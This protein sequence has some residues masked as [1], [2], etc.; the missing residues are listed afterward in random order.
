MQVGAGVQVPNTI[1]KQPWRQI[2]GVRL[3]EW[4]GHFKESD[5]P[6]ETWRYRQAEAWTDSDAASRLTDWVSV[7]TGKSLNKFSTKPDGHIECFEKPRISMSDS[8]WFLVLIKMNDNNCSPSLLVTNG[9]QQRALI[10][11]ETAW[12]KLARNRATVYRGI[13]AH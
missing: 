10:A 13:R 8:D 2:I 9:S 3:T 4:P 5:L 7:F 6:P 1:L 11:S 12:A